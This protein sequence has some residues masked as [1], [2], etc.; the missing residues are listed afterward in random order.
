MNR[1]KEKRLEIESTIED[2]QI[3]DFLLN[4]KKDSV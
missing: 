3:V 4:H 2:D 1:D